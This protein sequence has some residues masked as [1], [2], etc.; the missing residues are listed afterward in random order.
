MAVQPPDLPPPAR[1]P[2]EKELSRRSRVGALNPVLIVAVIVLI[3]IVAFVF[4]A[5]G[6]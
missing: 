4:W 3:G 6:G 5:R 1:D 2:N